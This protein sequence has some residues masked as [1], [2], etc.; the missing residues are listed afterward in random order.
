MREALALAICLVVGVAEARAATLRGDRLSVDI[1]ASANV[2]GIL[3]D[4]TTLDVRPGP[5]VTLCDVA[6]GRFEAPA[7]TG[8]DGEEG[9]ALRFREACALDDVIG[10]A[11][12]ERV[13][14]GRHIDVELEPAGWRIIRRRP[15][16]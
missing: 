3:V 7:T 5:L 11:V 16:R 4:A 9:L 15:A 8:R 1:D 13:A 14:A 10:G 12:P 2:T 6:A